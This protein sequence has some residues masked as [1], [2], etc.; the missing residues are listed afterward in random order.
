MCQKYQTI[1]WPEIENLGYYLGVNSFIKEKF[2]N[3]GVQWEIEDEFQDWELYNV[4]PLGD[5]CYFGVWLETNEGD[6]DMIFATI[7]HFY[8]FYVENNQVHFVPIKI[9]G[10]EL[11]EY[12]TMNKLFLVE[13]TRYQTFVPKISNYTLDIPQT[14]NQL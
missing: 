4:I 9:A 8:T 7:A 10:D 1:L 2:E 12:V 6:L 11:A 14:N 5:D 3:Q 13:N